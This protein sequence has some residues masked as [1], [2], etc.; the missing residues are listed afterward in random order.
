M[1]NSSSGSQRLSIFMQY[2]CKNNPAGDNK[3]PSLIELSQELGVSVASLRE[4]MEV[5]RTMGLIEVKPRT[6]IQ[7]TPYSFSKTILTS[8]T[9]A[10]EKDPANFGSFSDLRK[11]I[12]AA[13]WK[14][15]VSLLN[16]EDIEDLKQIID[17]AL[18]KLKA[19]PPQIPH[20]EH[21]IF[22]LSIYRKL[23]NPFVTGILESF[24]KAYEDNGLDIYTDIQYLEQVWSYHQKSVEAISSGELDSGF[25]SFAE[26]MDLI[27]KRSNSTKINRFE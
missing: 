8:L 27:S 24:W 1:R 10:M 12:E 11:H 20:E 21:K 25:R 18:A 7:R 22:H 15:A 5:A 3:V 4:Q 9:Y 17:I 2:L 19:K 23:N 16:P 13:Y 26:H 14:E 6:G